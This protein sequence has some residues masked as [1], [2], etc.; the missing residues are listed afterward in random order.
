[1]QD[2][3]PSPNLDED[4]QE[5]PRPLAPWQQ[6]ALWCAGVAVV[7]VVLYRLSL[8][9]GFVYDDHQLIVSNPAVRS[10]SNVWEAWTHQLWSQSIAKG[11]YYRPLLA[12]LN[13]FNYALFKMRPAGWHAVGILLHVVACWGVFSLAR[14][15]GFAIHAAGAAALIFAVHPVHVECVSWVSAQSD[16]LA[17]AFYIFG[18]SAFLASREG[19]RRGWKLAIAL[20][21]AAG[22]MFTKEIGVTFPA[23][24]L[25]YEWCYSRGEAF[26]TRVRRSVA[27]AAPFAVAALVY[28]VA[29]ASVMR[30]IRPNH[31]AVS[32]ASVLLTL[33]SVVARYVEILL[34]PVGLNTLY[35]TP[36]VRTFSML[37]VGIPLLTV[38]AVVALL[39]YVARRTGDPLIVFASW[40][41]LIPLLPTLYLPIFPMGNFVR[42]RYVYLSS[43]G[44]VLVVVALIA[45]IPE[46]WAEQPYLARGIVCAVLVAVLGLGAVF[47]QV[48]WANDMA[49]AYRGFQTNPR[50]VAAELYYAEQ[51]AQQDRYAQA[52]GILEHVMQQAPEER[53][54]HLDQMFQQLAFVD[55]K[56]G[57]MDEGKAAFEEAERHTENAG[58]SLGKA[59]RAQ[60]YAMYGDTGKAL[61]LF[62]EAVRD[63]PD[64]APEV[65]NY[66]YT[67]YLVRRYEDA[68]WAF[69]HFLTLKDD[70]KGHRYLGE[71]LMH[72]QKLAEAES[73]LKRSIAMNPAQEGA[74]TALGLIYELQ[75]HKADAVR[76]YQ[77]ELAEHPQN[78]AAADR[79]AALNHR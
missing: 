72:E 48:Y 24:V 13:C 64:S 75:G 56:L 10:L 49:V 40:W 59:T 71:T 25:L 7:C 9:F 43:V 73:E 4:E 11:N 46:R 42:D 27:A 55:Y 12:T 16:T 26:A 38:L 17:A 66:A 79:L 62:S 15:L 29:R 31:M 21:L 8:G 58:T 23:M 60:L 39:W 65:Y 32:A 22:A 20:L 33:P 45:R 53:M 70:A 41:M 77:T 61:E 69:R 36:Y 28:L 68:E 51:L 54:G 19:T 47:Q 52:R 63:T 3:S 76:E 35:Y 37:D 78:K 44:L 14:R 18:F 57:R 67:L 74:H 34:F 50:N 1:M 5:H 2:F 30:G 6:S